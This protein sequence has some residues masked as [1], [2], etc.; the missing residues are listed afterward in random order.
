MR[1]LLALLLFSVLVL[2]EPPPV[3]TPAEAL[4]TAAKGKT[5]YIELLGR[6]QAHAPKLRTTEECY[7][8]VLILDALKKIETDKGYNLEAL[9]TSPLK[10]YAAELTG[11]TAK[12]VRVAT[13]D[14]KALEAYFRWADDDTRGRA[15]EA[16]A[17][18]LNLA[19]DVKALLEW[20]KRLR[21][22]IELLV[23]LDA[24]AFARQGF[25]TLQTTTT[26]KLLGLRKKL[27]PDDCRALVK[28]A[29][30]ANGLSE[31][32][33]FLETEIVETT[34]VAYLK[35]LVDWVVIAS[36]NVRALKTGVTALSKG[37]PGHVL[38]LAL[39]KLVALE[40]APDAALAPEVVAS[41]QSNQVL[42]LGGYFAEAYRD[43]SV[44]DSVAPF[45]LG[46]IRGLLE[47]YRT[48]GFS[49][50]AKELSKLALRLAVQTGLQK[51]EIEG[52]YRVSI[53]QWKTEDG[54]RRFEKRTDGILTVA[55]AGR[56]ALVESLTLQS[57][58]SS[59]PG[60]TTQY[61]FFNTTYQATDDSYEATR[62][63]VDA[64]DAIPPSIKNF[65]LKFK[66]TKE[67]ISG[68]FSNGD[69]YYD[70]VGEQIEKYTMAKP[71]DAD[72]LPAVD[73]VYSG[74]VNGRTMSLNVVQHVERVSGTLTLPGR[75][76]S[77]PLSF[78]HFNRRR[79]E[80]F[81]TSGETDSGIWVQL[82]GRLADKGNT[83]VLQYIVGG[84]G[85]K[86]KELRLRKDD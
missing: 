79:N 83:L 31:I 56:A 86:L 3:P 13:D 41:L 48:L 4:V 30:T 34:D 85:V 52:T 67:G 55:S 21:E 25:E 72:E 2:A 20:H 1:L 23:K 81:V 46:T 84:M 17:D 33:A 29:R 64:I 75:I 76:L 18:S 58:H 27:G 71:A 38:V 19:E 74:E 9:G 6:L 24:K 69:R 26:K 32:L 8:Y 22:T 16:Q 5:E 51:G 53:G 60:L 59:A 70:L 12:F 7:G 63:S 11:N 42:E 82:R 36:G 35:Q 28:E 39:S 10:D 68:R 45:A 61:S 44:P 49:D 14:W 40:A 37:V 66:L 80:F 15:A 73:G 78:G 43:R 47:R 77:I 65:Y 54:V 50:R 57:S 62:F